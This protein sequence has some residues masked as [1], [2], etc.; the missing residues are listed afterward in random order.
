MPLLVISLITDVEDETVQVYG[1]IRIVVFVRY[2]SVNLHIEFTPI[3][4]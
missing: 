3:T 4:S 1:N 2:K